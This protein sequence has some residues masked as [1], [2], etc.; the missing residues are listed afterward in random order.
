MTPKI[1]HG[2]E[3]SGLYSPSIEGPRTYSADNFIWNLR[4]YAGEVNTASCICLFPTM[5][6]SKTPWTLGTTSLEPMSLELSPDFFFSDGAVFTDVSTNGAPIWG[7]GAGEEQGQACSWWTVAASNCNRTERT[8][9]KRWDEGP[10]SHLIPA[11]ITMIGGS[12][13]LCVR[14]PSLERG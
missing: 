2:G 10:K 8:T 11:G 3:D 6:L 12:Q 14:F 7:P 13:K 9:D 4:C 5:Q 1:S